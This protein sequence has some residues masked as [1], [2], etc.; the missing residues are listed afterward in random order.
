MVICEHL[1]N[2]RCTVNIVVKIEVELYFL[3][4]ISSEFE[5]YR[6]YNVNY[7]IYI[8]NFFKFCIG[9]KYQETE[10]GL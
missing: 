4:D 6:N 2:I 7:Y 5:L 3:R 9:T 10:I 1:K 8:N